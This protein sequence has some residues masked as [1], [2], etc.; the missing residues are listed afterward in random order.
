MRKN[1]YLLQ[2]IY[3]R[4]TE[5]AAV[6]VEERSQGQLLTRNHWRIM[7]ITFDCNLVWESC[8]MFHNKVADSFVSECGDRQRWHPWLSQGKCEER[9]SVKLSDCLCKLELSSCSLVPEA[10]HEVLCQP[11][12]VFF[13]FFSLYVSFLCIKTW[14]QTSQIPEFTNMIAINHCKI[15]GNIFESTCQSAASFFLCVYVKCQQLMITHK[16][17]CNLMNR[18]CCQTKIRSIDIKLWVAG[19]LLLT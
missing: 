13:C 3:L 12:L 15:Y 9:R 2:A 7:M 18:L 5:W 1:S 19:S 17:D 16:F 6:K 11:A 4:Y 14:Q 10:V 8:L